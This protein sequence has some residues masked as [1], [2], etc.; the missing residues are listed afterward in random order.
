MTWTIHLNGMYSI[1]QYRGA[2]TNPT[3]LTT[4]IVDTIGFLDLPTH[5]LGRQSKTLNIWHDFCRGKDGVEPVSGLPFGVL[6]LFS[7]IAQPDIELQFWTWTG[8]GIE[9][10][11]V[12]RRAWDA[13]RFAGIISAREQHRDQ[14]PI[15]PSPSSPGCP[16]TVTLVQAIVDCLNDFLATPREEACSVLNLYLYPVFIAGTQYNILSSAQ[17]A[18]IERFWKEFLLDPE[19]EGAVNRSGEAGGRTVSDGQAGGDAGPEGVG[20]PYVEAPLDILHE[21]WTNSNRRTSDQIAREWGLE[22][23]LF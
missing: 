2:I 1:L 8:A 19:G 20:S 18:C 21:L 13:I 4:D 14:M 9:A 16:P 3:A 5:I 7:M 12:Q 15:Q 23:G 6:D 22:V 11:P 10:K 17:K